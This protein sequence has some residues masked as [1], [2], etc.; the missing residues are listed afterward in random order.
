MQNN[1][2]ITRHVHSKM[3]KFKRDYYCAPDRVL[4]ATFVVDRQQK[5]K[6]QDFD[7]Y[8]QS[9]ILKLIQQVKRRSRKCFGQSKARTAGFFYGSAR[10]NPT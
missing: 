1:I 3:A 6:C 10:K 2:L 5:K 4:L 9:N 7:T 8:F